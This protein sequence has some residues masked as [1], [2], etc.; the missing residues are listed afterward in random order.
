MKRGLS[1]GNQPKIES[2]YPMEIKPMLELTCVDFDSI[3]S[4]LMRVN[5]EQNEEMGQIKLQTLLDLTRIDKTLKDKIEQG[6]INNVDRLK[7]QI[8]DLNDSTTENILH[9]KDLNL[10]LQDRVTAKKNT[11]LLNKARK[12]SQFTD[13]RIQARLRKLQKQ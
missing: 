4:K 3:K 11:K 13:N 12:A 6:T 10:T 7:R 1:P 8:N 5:C 9:L 2:I